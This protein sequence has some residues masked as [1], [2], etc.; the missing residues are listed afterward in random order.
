MVRAFDGDSTMTSLVPSPPAAEAFPAE[1]RFGVP[2]AAFAAAV[3]LA[4]AVL[5]AA[6]VL[7]GAFLAGPLVAGPLVAGTVVAGAVAAVFAACTVLAGTLPVLASAP[8]PVTLLGPPGAGFPASPT[9]RTAPGV[10]RD[11]ADYYGEI[12][13]QL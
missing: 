1:P 2:E 3:V 7:A 12:P 6:V 11:S 8:R 10:P 4:A 5:A 13:P 9:V